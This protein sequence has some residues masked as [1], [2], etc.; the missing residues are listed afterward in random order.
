M[1]FFLGAEIDLDPENKSP[2]RGLV[3]SWK[4]GLANDGGKDDDACFMDAKRQIT[5]STCL[6]E[7]MRVI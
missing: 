2:K 3:G 5:A 1:Q 4:D 7:R 6:E